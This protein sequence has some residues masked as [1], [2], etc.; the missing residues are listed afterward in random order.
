[1]K[2]DMTKGSKKLLLKFIKDSKDLR[3]KFIESESFEE[4][5]PIIFEVFEF[6]DAQ[7][8]EVKFDFLKR[9]I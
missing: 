8:E 1:M 7:L 2:I 9:R 5:Y 3:V 4:F 6:T